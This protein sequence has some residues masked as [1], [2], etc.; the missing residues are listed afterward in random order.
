MTFPDNPIFGET[1]ALRVSIADN[2]GAVFT[3][4][5]AT[6]TI[7]DEAE[8]VK[9]NAVACTVDN[10]AGEQRVY[11][12]ETFSTANGYVEDET[13][14]ATFKVT[15]SDGYAEKFEASFVVKAANDE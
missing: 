6:V 12:V 11:Y 2:D 15:T 13:Y 4:A 9:R 8:V 14:F 10:T 1:T 3:I 7:K 5:S